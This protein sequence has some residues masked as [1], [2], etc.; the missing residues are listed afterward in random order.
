[1]THSIEYRAGWRNANEQ[2]ELD[3]DTKAQTA[4]NLI[5]TATTRLN[6]VVNVE[7]QRGVIDRARQEL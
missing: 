2:L 4:R 3:R 1:M 5:A 6:A 7:Y